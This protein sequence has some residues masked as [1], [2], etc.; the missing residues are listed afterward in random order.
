VKTT[1]QIDDD[2]LPNVFVCGDVADTGVANMN[3]K[4]AQRQAEI[5]AH[6][7][8]LAAWDKKPSYIYEPGWGDG[9]IK[10]S[11]GLVSARPVPIGSWR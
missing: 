10:L 5:A 11:V 6:N 1:L 3:S 9:V 2:S 4:I 7:V 8:V